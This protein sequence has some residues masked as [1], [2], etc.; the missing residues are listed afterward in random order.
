[1]EAVNPPLTSVREEA[2]P[3]VMWVVP[4]MFA[5]ES[6][7]FAVDMNIVECVQEL[8][9]QAIE[10]EVG[11]EGECMMRCPKVLKTTLRREGDVKW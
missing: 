10:V 1:M 4:N 2:V 7:E 8:Y 6:R 3:P 11:V 9:E 5:L